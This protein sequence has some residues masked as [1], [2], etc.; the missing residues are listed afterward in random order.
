MQTRPDSGLCD[1]YGTAVPAGD[2]PEGRAIDG[3]SLWP[4]HMVRAPEALPLPAGAR[5]MG[6]DTSG[7]CNRSN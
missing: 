1:M 7:R 5:G 2:D 6:A 3:G 4:G